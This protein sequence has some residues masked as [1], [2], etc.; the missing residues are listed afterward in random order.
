MGSQQGVEREH[1]TERGMAVEVAL[2]VEVEEEGVD[3]TLDDKYIVHGIAC[4][5]D[6]SDGGS[7]WVHDEGD[8]SMLWWVIC[9]GL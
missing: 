1:G 7:P 4:G 2:A 6:T 8:G 9:R 3:G 5:L